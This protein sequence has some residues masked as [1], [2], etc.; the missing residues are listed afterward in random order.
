[1]AKVEPLHRC[2]ACGRAV[3]VAAGHVIRAC[4]CTAPVVG[5]MSATVR[6]VGALQPPKG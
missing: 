5:S 2:S 4:T 6:G 1:M 3:I